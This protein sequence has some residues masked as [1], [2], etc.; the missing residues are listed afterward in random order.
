MANP[1]ALFGSPK[2]AFVASDPNN[3]TTSWT[4][5]TYGRQVSMTDPLNKTVYYSYNDAGFLA[6]VTDREER[7]REFTHNA[8]GQ[9]VEERWIGSDGVSVIET[10]AFAFDAY[11]Q[12]EA[13]SNSMGAY[14]FR[15]DAYGQVAEVA[16]PWG[17]TLTFAYDDYGNRTAINDS[18]GGS[19]TSSYV[20]GML[21]TRTF[22]Q[23][24]QPTLRIDQDHDNYGRL[25]EQRRYS[26]AAGT[27]L[28]ARSIYEYD[29]VGRLVSLVHRD[30]SNG[31]IAEYTWEYNDA[32]QLVSQT[33]HGRTVDY[34]YDAQG[35]LTA[36][37]GGVA[38]IDYTYDANGNR[39]G[40][41]DSVDMG[42]RLLTN[43][44]WNYS[45]SDEGNV[46]QK[47]HID[48]GIN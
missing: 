24:G 26:D 46:T 29:D 28:V 10:I 5:D 15:Y 44:I 42:N 22:S 40:E 21:A 8:Y 27:S 6:S 18:F 32:G 35:Q 37:E 30:G 39:N 41:D 43:G 19:I 12:L 38:D 2:C 47:V 16:G 7:R 14:W 17:V 45:Y 20:A 25:T 48:D 13:A 11:G 34:T 9:M 36:E 33:D 1:A 4:Y 23:T 3:N 31:L